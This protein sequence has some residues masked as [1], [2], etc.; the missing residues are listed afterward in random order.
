[1]SGVENSPPKTTTTTTTTPTTSSADLLEPEK[2]ISV[3]YNARFGSF[4]FSS[5]AIEEYNLR[6][7]KDVP[8][9]RM[10]TC[11]GIDRTDAVMA[12]ICKEM[13]PKANGMFA[14]IQIEKVPA[15]FSE[16]F[17]IRDYDGMETVCISFRKYQLECIL[18]IL[19]T[20][21]MSN[22]EKIE[23]INLVFSDGN[24]PTTSLDDDTYNDDDDDDEEYKSE[25]DGER[26][27]FITKQK[28]IKAHK[29]GFLRENS[30]T[31]I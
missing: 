6:K 1:M 26:A 29:N 3:M 31:K 14:N 5:E 7:P 17:S 23:M 15:R 20:P 9:M 27:K 19:D 8:E 18:R 16:Y 28:F 22:D 25:N 10:S 24:K 2:T 13:G 4:S 30:H 12:Q 11:V 21:R